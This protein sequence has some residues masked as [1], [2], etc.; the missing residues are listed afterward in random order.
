MQVK[1]LQ[2]KLLPSKPPQDLLLQVVP[3]AR[4]SL[5]FALGFK[6]YLCSSSTK[7]NTISLPRVLLG[8]QVHIRQSPYL[9]MPPKEHCD[10]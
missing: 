4:I 9:A 7:F 5:P 10:V 1:S 3:K 2:G 8:T 6:G